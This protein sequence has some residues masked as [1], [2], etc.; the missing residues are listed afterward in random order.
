MLTQC[1]TTEPQE[2][3]CGHSIPGAAVCSECL[4]QFLPPGNVAELRGSP[5]LRGSLEQL[6]RPSPAGLPLQVTELAALST[7]EFSLKRLVP[8]LDTWHYGCPC[9]ACIIGSCLCK[10]WFYQSSLPRDDAGL[11]TVNSIGDLS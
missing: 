4:S 11:R 10:L 3:L 1:P 2:H 6:E 5:S 8:L 9:Q 7:P